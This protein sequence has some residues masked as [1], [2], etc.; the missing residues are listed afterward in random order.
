MFAGM[1][2]TG[3]RP[4]AMDEASPPLA[5]SQGCGQETTSAVM[6]AR[7]HEAGRHA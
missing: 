7:R 3:T 4:G 1:S 2:G 6:T 5:P